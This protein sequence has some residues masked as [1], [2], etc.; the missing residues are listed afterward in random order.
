MCPSYKFVLTRFSLVARASKD[1][2]VVSQGVRA[3]LRG[4]S[5]RGWAGRPAS[6]KHS[7][8]WA[9]KEYVG[10]WTVCLPIDISRF[11]IV[12][13]SFTTL[14]PCAPLAMQIW[15]ALDQSS[16]F[17]PQCPS[18]P[19]DELALDCSPKLQ[20]GHQ[21]VGCALTANTW[22]ARGL[23]LSCDVAPAGPREEQTGYGLISHILFQMCA[24]R[25]YAHFF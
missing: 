9:A 24:V 17:P 23:L 3:P 14:K 16:V 22:P 15:C 20:R 2:P 11:L 8:T 19:C 25:S 18:I 21:R 13:H 5:Q 12:I 7:G 10:V 1:N 4:T 6:S